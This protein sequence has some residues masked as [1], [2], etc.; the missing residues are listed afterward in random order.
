MAHRLRDGAGFVTL[1]QRPCAH[2]KFADPSASITL[3]PS[4]SLIDVRG[5]GARA[6]GAGVGGQ[7]SQGWRSAADFRVSERPW[8][9]AANVR[10]WGMGSPGPRAG[11]S[12]VTPPAAGRQKSRRMRSSSVRRSLRLRRSVRENRS[13]GRRGRRDHGRCRRH[14]EGGC[15]HPDC[16]QSQ[17]RSPPPSWGHRAPS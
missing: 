8:R 6:P 17:F 10:R 3:P 1:P 11:T 7:R 12:S 2:K 4:P 9:A 13:T 14:G 16:R 5:G 15:G